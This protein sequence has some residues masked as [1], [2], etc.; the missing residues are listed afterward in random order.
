MLLLWLR[1][2]ITLATSIQTKTKKLKK[3]NKIKYDDIERWTRPN[4]SYPVIYL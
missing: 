2:I 3:Y 1:K 4:D